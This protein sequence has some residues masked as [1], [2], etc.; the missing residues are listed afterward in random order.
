MRL[1]LQAFR[2]GASVSWLSWCY[3]L[4]LFW[5]HFGTLCLNLLQSVTYK[6]GKFFFYPQVRQMLDQDLPKAGFEDEAWGIRTPACKE[7]SDP[8]EE[9]RRVRK[10]VEK[11]KVKNKMDSADKGSLYAEIKKATLEV[12]EQEKFFINQNFNRKLV[13]RPVTLLIA[14]YCVCLC[15]SVHSIVYHCVPLCIIVYQFCLY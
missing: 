2:K 12:A 3:L 11:R 9:E 10:W 5:G 14:Y 15:I 1:L 13:G 7:D 6:F 8:R 4:Q